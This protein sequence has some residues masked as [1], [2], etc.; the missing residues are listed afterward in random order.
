MLECVCLY[1]TGG[2]ELS[3]GALGAQQGGTFC[4]GMHVKTMD[5]RGMS[6]WSWLLHLLCPACR[7]V[8]VH[9]HVT[10][11]RILWYPLS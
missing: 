11:V 4:R 6:L 5:S 1:V 10:T 7:T 8:H 2:L 9:C 3:V